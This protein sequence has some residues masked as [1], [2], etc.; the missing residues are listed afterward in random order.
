MFNN[1]GK[2]LYTFGKEGN[3]NG[4]FDC[5]RCLSLTKAGQL[6]VCDRKNYR[7]QIF[8]MSGKSL[9]KFGTKGSETGQFDGPISSAFL[10]DGRLVVADVL[11]DRVQI[12]EC[13]SLFQ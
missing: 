11:N 1:N 5:P 13:N 4:E 8:D 7:I 10:S 12:L 3:G 9:G 6:V 2:F